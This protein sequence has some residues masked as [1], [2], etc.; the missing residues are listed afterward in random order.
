L[1]AKMFTRPA[2]LLVLDE[3]TNDLDAETLELLESLLVE[4]AGT[5]LLVSHDRAFL[6][7]VATST[8]VFEGE[9]R[10]KEYVGG[11]DDWARQ[12]PREGAASEFEPIAK[13]EPVRPQK[14][15]A[16]KLS[17]KEERELAGLPERIEKL[18]SEQSALHQ[19]M[20][21]PAFY[22]QAAAEITKT[23]GRL[24]ELQ[25]ELEAAYSR[26]EKLLAIKEG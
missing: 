2:N 6:N 9:G 14:E 24:E 3:P 8:L 10:F 4:F 20:A 1:L 21:D 17:Y 22:R 11:Y 12:R 15:R 7:N 16:R 19:K 23:N 18:E 13:L 25:K 26:W 5:I